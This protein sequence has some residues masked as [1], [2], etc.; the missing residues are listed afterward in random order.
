[1]WVICTIPSIRSQTESMMQISALVRL[2]KFLICKSRIGSATVQIRGLK[3]D[4]NEQ[5]N[6]E[7]YQKVNQESKERTNKKDKWSILEQEQ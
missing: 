3:E 2:C 1:M 4:H 5:E 6:K 7:Y